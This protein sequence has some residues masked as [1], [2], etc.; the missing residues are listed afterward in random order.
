MK[1]NKLD[2]GQYGYRS[3]NRK[4][5]VAIVAVCAVAILLQLAA[6]NFTTTDGAR[7]ILT[8]MAILTVLPMANMASPMLAGWKYK[9]SPKEL[10][11]R[12]QKHESDFCIL[13]DLIITSKE[14]IMPMAAVIVHPTGI[15]GYC[16]AQKIDV[17]KAERFLN[18]MLE[19]HRLDGNAK[20]IKDE[21]T[22]F[23]RLENLKPASEYEDDGSVQTAAGLLK[24]I[25]M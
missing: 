16:T 10:Y 20:V 8:V 5:Q 6:R 1:R 25:S 12:I 15:Y 23:T 13:Y 2:K 17:K 19:S 11:E 9:D 18:D 4:M 3:S 7:N 21:K 14:S 22:W 24:S